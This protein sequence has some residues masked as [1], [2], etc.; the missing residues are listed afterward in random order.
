MTTATTTTTKFDYRAAS[1]AILKT[2]K[3][4]RDRQV[5]ARRF[6][7]DMPGRQT[8]EQ[9]GKSFGITRE[10][11][12]QIEKTTLIKLAQ[13]NLAE[14]KNAAA[15]IR[16]ELEPHGGIAPTPVV[17]A[18][19]GANNPGEQA[20]IVFLATLTTDITVIDEDD[21][22]RA[23]LSLSSAFPAPKVRD[24]IR[25]LVQA[26]KEH[27]KP[28]PLGQLETLIKSDA[29]SETIANI[30][31]ISKQLAHHETQWGLISWPEVNPKSI[32]DKTYLVLTK[33]TKPMHFSEISDHIKAS[34]F[35]R[36]D[37]TVQAVHNELIKDARFILIGRGIYALAEWG[38]TPGT[39]ADIIIDVLREESPLHKDEIVKRVL[40]RRQVK[41]TTVIL[42][43]Q[44]KDHFVRVAK[45]TYRLKEQ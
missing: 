25:Q 42:N 11:V 19:L 9:I 21:Q 18:T 8:L 36:R 3:R 32:R 14:V 15:L 20:Y 12:R 5:I 45:A 13:L 29:A 37:V 30:A 6:G 31:S 38:Y 43:L 40:K 2:L 34:N 27:A 28:L 7:F 4:D 26:A 39:V 17:S 22:V 24:I 41:T 33:H 10:R 16:Q 44:E 35:A 1:A 23:A